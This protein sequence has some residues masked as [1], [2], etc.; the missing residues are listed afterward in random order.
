MEKITNEE[1]AKTKLKYDLLFIFR[2]K[3]KLTKEESKKFNYILDILEYKLPFLK[4]WQS[5]Y[6]KAKYIA[7]NHMKIATQKKQIAKLSD[8][9]FDRVFDKGYRPVI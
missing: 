9:L 6:Q 3:D 5:D 7:F 4:Y 1:K 8:K 2:Y